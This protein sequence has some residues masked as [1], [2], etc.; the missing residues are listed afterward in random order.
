MA[1]QPTDRPT[2]RP[3]L[4]HGAIFH[5]GNHGQTR[6]VLLQVSGILMHS[7]Y[8]LILS[9][10]GLT[11]RLGIVEMCEVNNCKGVESK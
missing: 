2:D 10:D 8:L 11:G 5:S 6:E 7:L 1:E 9:L 3:N 4:L